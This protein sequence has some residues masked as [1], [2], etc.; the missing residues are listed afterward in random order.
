MPEELVIRASLIERI[1]R[2]NLRLGRHIKA[3]GHE[4]LKVKLA[5][6]DGSL[7][8]KD[9]RTLGLTYTEIL[10]ILAREF[11]EASTTVACLRW[12]VVHIRGDA[13]DEGLDWPDLPQIRP[14]AKKPKPVRIVEAPAADPALL[15]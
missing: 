9:G 4:L 12:Y 3:R 8:L 1:R 14:R 7:Q 15:A 13:R 11:P 10:Q 5:H 6:P 2:Q